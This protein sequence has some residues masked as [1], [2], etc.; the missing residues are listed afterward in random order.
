[1][2]ALVDSYLQHPDRLGLDKAARRGYVV[3][4]GI[5]LEVLGPERYARTITRT[6]L[7]YLQEVI[8]SLPPHA[9]RRPEYQDVPLSEIAADATARRAAGEKLP[10]LRPDVGNKY[11][12]TVTRIFVYAVHENMIDRNPAD[13]LTIRTSGSVRTALTLAQLRRMFH[14]GYA[15]TDNNWIPLVALL[16]G[17]RGNEIAQMDTTD[18]RLVNGV[19][20]FHVSVWTEDENGTRAKIDKS[21][22]N[23]PSE[24]IVPIHRRL[25]ELGFLHH[26]EERRKAK[27]AKLFDV[28]LWG[29]SYWDSIRDAMYSLMDAAGIRTELDFAQDRRGCVSAGECS[30]GEACRVEQ[31]LGERSGDFYHVPALA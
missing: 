21:L 6:D 24:R 25:I 10:S 29:D 2:A 26:V 22:K 11:L 7:R 4:G 27:Y 18:V 28:K 15:L 1:M 23:R 14:R 3:A 12:R 30:S 13:R 31:A 17:M 19:W 9:K 8:L 20:C 5:L 16:Q